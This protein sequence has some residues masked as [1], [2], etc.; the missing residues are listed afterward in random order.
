MPSAGVRAG[1]QEAS[2]LDIV[3]NT[4]LTRRDILLGVCASCAFAGS[5]AF[6]QPARKWAAVVIGVNGAA[7]LPVLS[8]AASGAR[9]MAEWL[10]NEHYDVTAF[11]DDTGPVKASPIFEAIDAIV[12][13][14]RYERL[15]VYFAGHGFVS[16]Q[17]E[18][19]L[20]SKAPHNPNEAISLTASA[21]LARYSTIPNVV[22]I[23]DACR[24]RAV[25]LGTANIQ[26]PN[27]FP[28]PGSFPRVPVNVDQFL[29]TR[30]SD[31]AFGGAAFRE[32]QGIF[33]G[34]TPKPCSARLP[35]HHQT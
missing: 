5:R 21:Y 16:Q 9:D 20:L 19:W 25:D 17:S 22:F 30:I 13:S 1:A 3:A 23:S 33:T 35:A 31:S 24:S 18:F 27:K 12:G 7:G 29:A 32:R 8:A 28:S 2:A 4:R 14:G 6:A 10:K 11:V 15:V 34:Y 26:G